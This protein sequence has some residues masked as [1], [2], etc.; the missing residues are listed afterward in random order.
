MTPFL[1]SISFC[2]EVVKEV[3][4]VMAGVCRFGLRPGLK[5]FASLP[6]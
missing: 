3:V 1:S 5:Y 4:V 6:A 2:S